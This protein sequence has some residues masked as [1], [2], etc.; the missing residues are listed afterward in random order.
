MLAV[1]MLAGL[2][3]GWWV[4][5]V[6]GCLPLHSSLLSF[7]SFLNTK[8]GTS[9]FSPAP[10]EPSLLC[11][12]LDFSVDS[13][14]NEAGG[15]LSELEGVGPLDPHSVLHMRARGQRDGGQVFSYLGAR[16]EDRLALC[17][18]ALPP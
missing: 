7:L 15:G 13:V 3:W 12:P 4:S 1:E 18:P 14:L 8:L 11:L 10:F 9:W 16:M 17:Q 2:G 6:G 5:H